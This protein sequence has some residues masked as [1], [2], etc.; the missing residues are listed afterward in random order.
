MML[1][2]YALPASIILALI[3]LVDSVYLTWIKITNQ[4][5]ICS[6]IGDCEAVNTSVYSEIAGIPIAFLGVGA[7]LA[8][9]AALSS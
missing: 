7:Y 4:E 2:K 3:G 6:S 8:M 1:K 5:A 9:I